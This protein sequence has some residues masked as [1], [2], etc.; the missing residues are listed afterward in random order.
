MFV[1]DF[2]R[3]LLSG[4]ARAGEHVYRALYLAGQG[5]SIISPPTVPGVYELRG[6]YVVYSLRD[7]RHV[8]ATLGSP[9]TELV[10]VQDGLRQPRFP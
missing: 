7:S 2:A 6:R 3:M 8:E 5:L 1:R 9:D 4:T 10:G